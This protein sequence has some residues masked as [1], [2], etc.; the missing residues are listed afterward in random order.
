MTNSFDIDPNRI[1]ND[2]RYKEA[3][4]T[5]RAGHHIRLEG[6]SHYPSDRP[7]TSIWTVIFC[8]I[9]VPSVLIVAAVMLGG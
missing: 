8:I 3:R 4:R 6:D 5:G 7:D 1:E 2:I 9:M